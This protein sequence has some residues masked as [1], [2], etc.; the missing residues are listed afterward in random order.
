[1]HHRRQNQIYLL[2]KKKNL[3]WHL[4]NEQFADGLI[5]SLHLTSIFAIGKCGTEAKQAA[6]ETR[7]V[8]Q[9]KEQECSTARCVISK[10]RPGITR[11]D[12]N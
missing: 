6:N 8:L 10:T 5:E 1:M 4:S 11:P 12:Y 7:T 9:H 3:I 2:L